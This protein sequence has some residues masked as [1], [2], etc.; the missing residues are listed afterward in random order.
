MLK[1]RLKDFLMFMS[2]FGII[3]IPFIFKGFM[4]DWIPL[5]VAIIAVYMSMCPLF[6]TPMFIED[7]YGEFIES[8]LNLSKITM[9]IGFTLQYLFKQDMFTYT[10]V[11]CGIFLI[12]I[13]IYVFKKQEIDNN[14]KDT[15]NS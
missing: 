12:Y 9:I 3:L 1:K 10:T 13:F 7:K 4:E 14:V 8:T 15:K 2:C 6:L 11:Q 5:K